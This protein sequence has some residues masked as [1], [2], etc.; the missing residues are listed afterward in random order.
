MLRWE[1]GRKGMVDG[2]REIGLEARLLIGGEEGADLAGSVL[3]LKH[4]ET[5]G[6]PLHAGGSY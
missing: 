5:G 6:L 3:R 2:E 1:E 4:R